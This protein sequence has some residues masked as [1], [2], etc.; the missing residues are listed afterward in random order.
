MLGVRQGLLDE[1]LDAKVVFVDPDFL[2]AHDIITSRGIRQVPPDGGQ[3]VLT[4]LGDEFQTPM[5][6]VP[7]C[8]Y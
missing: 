4:F 7:Q 1:L 6:T 8:E 5:M 3:S 2:K